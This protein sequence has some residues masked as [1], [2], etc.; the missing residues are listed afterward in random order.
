[1]TDP[2][3][4]NAAA[5]ALAEIFRAEMTL[6][7]STCAGCGDARPVAELRVY[8]DA[9]GVVLRCANCH[10][11]ELRLVRGPG[12]AWL[13]ARGIRALEIQLPGAER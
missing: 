6:A 11:V 7:V 12:R 10:A 13:D 5:G 9:P 1:V 8:L 3:D 4:G 2:L